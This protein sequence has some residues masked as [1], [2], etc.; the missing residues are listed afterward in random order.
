M[1][2]DNKDSISDKL[3]EVTPVSDDTGLS[4]PEYVAEFDYSEKLPLMSVERLDNRG[5]AMDAD[6]EFDLD[7]VYDINALQGSD[8]GGGGVWEDGTVMFDVDTVGALDLADGNADLTVPYFAGADDVTVD[9]SDFDAADYDDMTGCDAQDI[10][11]FG[12]DADD[13]MLID[14][15]I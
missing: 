10:T 14:G 9:I 12:A 4:R 1:N 2:S 5:A 7:P 3:A 13:I 8:A 11:D 6:Y 15:I